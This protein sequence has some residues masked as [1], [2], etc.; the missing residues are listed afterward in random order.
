MKKCSTNYWQT[1]F[2]NPYKKLY[3]LAKL[4]LPQVCKSESKVENH[5]PSTSKGKEEKS[6]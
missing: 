5:A 1:K 3:V 2:S 6:N 4:N